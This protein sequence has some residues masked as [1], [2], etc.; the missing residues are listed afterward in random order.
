M[1]EKNFDEL[2][3]GAARIHPLTWCVKQQK[4]IPTAGL[5]GSICCSCPDFVLNIGMCDPL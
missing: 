3:L 1:K 5:K 2:V 4:P